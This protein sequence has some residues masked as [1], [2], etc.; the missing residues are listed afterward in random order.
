MLVLTILQDSIYDEPEHIMV[1]MD[2]LPDVNENVEIYHPE[3]KG[4]I[5]TKMVSEYFK[6]T[7][8]ENKWCFTLYYKHIN[9]DE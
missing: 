8:N 9:Y 5:L 6:F 4:Y 7:N 3:R 1:E 2:K